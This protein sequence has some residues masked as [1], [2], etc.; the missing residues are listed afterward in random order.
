VSWRVWSGYA[1]GR[2]VREGQRPAS[3]SAGTLPLMVHS[4]SFPFFAV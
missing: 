4:P 2:N 3:R 1:F